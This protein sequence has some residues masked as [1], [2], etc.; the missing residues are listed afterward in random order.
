MCCIRHRRPSYDRVVDEYGQTGRNV[1]GELALV[2][3]QLEGRS[4]GAVGGHWLGANWSTVLVRHQQALGVGR[5]GVPRSTTHCP[6][7]FY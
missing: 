6:V 7:Y 2:V 4:V 1:W 5:H 3:G